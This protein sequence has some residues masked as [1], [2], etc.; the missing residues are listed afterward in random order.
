MAWQMLVIVA[1]LGIGAGL[2][3][4]GLRRAVQYGLAWHN[5]DHAERLA[6]RT[7]QPAGH[8]LKPAF[9]GLAMMVVGVVMMA[10]IDMTAEALR[11]AQPY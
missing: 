6:K 10:T 5:K 1:Q 2:L 7:G 4:G 11:P 9:I 3:L 8:S